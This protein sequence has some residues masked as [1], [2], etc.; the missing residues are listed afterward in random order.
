MTQLAED[1]SAPLASAGDGSADPYLRPPYEPEPGDPPARSLIDDLEALLDDGRSYVRAELSYQKT[2]ASFVSNRIGKAIGLALA[3]GVMGLLAAIGL[4][5]GLIIA[6]TPHL[7]AWGATA[8]VAGVLL[9]IAVLLMR[10]ASRN[11][12]SARGATS[13]G[14]GSH[15]GEG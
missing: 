12:A 15:G 3:A 14:A 11:W 4:T 7:T 13:G 9:L 6:L 1:R 10:R 5:V 8:L 2:R